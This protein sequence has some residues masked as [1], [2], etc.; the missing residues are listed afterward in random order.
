MSKITLNRSTKQSKI[1]FA[2]LNSRRE[3]VAARI[4]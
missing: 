4:D 3:P 1:E 2:D